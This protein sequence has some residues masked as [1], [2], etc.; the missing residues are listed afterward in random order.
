MGDAYMVVTEANNVE[1]LAFTYWQ[2]N[3]NEKA[4]AAGYITKSM[5]DYAKSELKKVIETLSS[6]CY[7]AHSR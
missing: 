6:L 3:A 5:Y 7:N 2:I 4:Y 1:S